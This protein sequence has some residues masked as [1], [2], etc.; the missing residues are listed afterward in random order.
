MKAKVRRKIQQKY[1]ESVKVRK[2]S[3]YVRINA[4]HLNEDLK[5]MCLL[6]DIQLDQDRSRLRPRTNT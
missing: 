6:K 5:Q 2:I 1:P 3:E 4:E